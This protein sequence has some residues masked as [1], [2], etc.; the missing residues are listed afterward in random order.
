MSR[1]HRRDATIGQQGSSMS[2]ELVALVRQRVATRFYDSPG[3]I[4]AMARAIVS[5]FHRGDGSAEWG[6]GVH[7]VASRTR[8][9]S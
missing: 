8:P 6:I 5:S 7:R 9:H 3:V 1:I 2:D 4:D